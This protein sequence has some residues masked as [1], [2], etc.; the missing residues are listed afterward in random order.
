MLV[1]LI[2]VGGP[3][4]A[5]KE[6]IYVNPRHVV[7]VRAATKPAGMEDAQSFVSEVVQVDGTK[8]RV[9]GSP[10]EVRKAFLGGAR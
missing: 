3:L 2:E 5:E 4:D 8:L 6:K 9:S 10:T 1:E 7:R